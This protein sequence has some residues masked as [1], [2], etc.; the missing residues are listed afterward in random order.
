MRRRNLSRVLH[1]VAAD[2]APSRATIA[3]R[4]GLTRA[5]VS[6][7][8][9]ELLGTGLLVELGPGRSG[10]VGRPGSVLALADTGPCGIGAEI[11]VDRLAVCATD[12]RG[13]VRARTVAGHPVPD[14]APGAVLAALRELIAGVSAEAR[15]AGLA[16]AGVAVAVPGLVGRDSAVVRHAPNL[17]WRDTDVGAALPVAEPL[18]VANEA[19][20]AALA[21]VW[22]A[23][24]G[25]ER[26][27]FL[28]VS[29]EA[30]IGGAL[31]LGGELVHGSGGFAGELGHVPVYPEGRSCGCGGR[32]C[33][34]QYAGEAALLRAAGLDPGPAGSRLAPLEERARA[35]DPAALRALRGAGRVLGVATAGAVN[36]LDPAAVVLG[37]TLARFGEWLLPSWERELRRRSVLPGRVPEVAVSALGSEGT[38]RGAAQS[39]VRA[40]LDDPLGRGRAAAGP[41]G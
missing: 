38:L 15:E 2:S 22:L 25:V 7:L 10:A 1:A 23:G 8:V 39:V 16:P 29:A 6:T 19:N 40:V 32:G 31:V 5:A 14:H 30:G 9:D 33:L 37:G 26:R 18:T 41:P 27:D 3:A 11:G 28:H 20:F 34:E 12:L 17:G 21:E 13:T 36:L 35:A 24:P 4:I